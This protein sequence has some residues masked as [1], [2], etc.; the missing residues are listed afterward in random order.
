MCYVK[1]KNQTNQTNQ[2]LVDMARANPSAGNSWMKNADLG[3]L[4]SNNDAWF[5]SAMAVPLNFDVLKADGDAEAVASD[6]LGWL[7]GM[8]AP[9]NRSLD[10]DL[11]SLDSLDN[12]GLGLGIMPLSLMGVPAPSPALSDATC[13]VMPTPD[14]SPAQ[15]PTKRR[16]PDAC[17]D[18][19]DG[20]HDATLKRLRNTE[21]ARKSRAR[22]A[23]KVDSLEVKVDAL[24]KEKS[25][26]TVR[27]AILENDATGFAQREDDLRRRVALLERQLMESRRAFV[28]QS[29][30][31]AF[32]AGSLQ[33]TKRKLELA[34]ALQ[35]I[36]HLAGQTDTSQPQITNYMTKRWKQQQIFLQLPKSLNFDS[37]SVGVPVVENVTQP[38]LQA[39]LQLL[40][41]KPDKTSALAEII[42]NRGN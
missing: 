39:M 35:Q 5:S 27:I 2:S 20:L 36:G 33:N 16:L 9:H 22:K 6:W 8:S 15:G 21:A 4:N 34:T 38:Q 3:V 32:Y 25:C 19:G 37:K 42:L 29:I 13:F 18:D 26:M 12:L 28:E 10:T 23:A 11:D 40:M 14:P 17:D 1:V 30:G 41:Q 7:E 31:V 24:E